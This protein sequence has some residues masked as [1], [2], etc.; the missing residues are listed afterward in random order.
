ML[1]RVRSVDGLWVSDSGVFLRRIGMLLC[2]GEVVKHS[3]E[4]L[5]V[6][7][8]E[9]QLPRGAEME[10]GSTVAKCEVR[11]RK[12]EVEYLSGCRGESPVWYWG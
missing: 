5:D 3:H 7:Q 9:G 10:R 4:R 6:L 11:V 2:V 8:C 12:S 1:C